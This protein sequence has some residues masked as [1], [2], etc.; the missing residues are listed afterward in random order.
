MLLLR[1]SLIR[2]CFTVDGHEGVHVVV[3]VRLGNLHLLQR[4]A[5]AGR[6]NHRDSARVHPAGPR[7]E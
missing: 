6:Q 5:V 2:L 1:H 4:V 3:N 7:R